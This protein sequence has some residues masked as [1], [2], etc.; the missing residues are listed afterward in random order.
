M[1][2]PNDTRIDFLY[3]SEQDMVDA[4]ATDSAQCVKT[5]EET[6]MLLAAEDAGITG[7]ADDPKRNFC[8]EQTWPSLL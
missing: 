7:I 1:S 8:E 5:M 4:Q 3:L 2:T 6:L